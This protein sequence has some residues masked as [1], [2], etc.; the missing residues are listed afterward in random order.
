MIDTELLNIL[1]CPKCR[2]EVKLSQDSE[3]II[4]ETC[5]LAYPIDNDIPIMLIDNAKEI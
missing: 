4:C 1:V 3:T 5:K 2:N